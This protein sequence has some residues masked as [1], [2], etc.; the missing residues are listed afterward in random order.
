MMSCASGLVGYMNMRKGNV[1]EIQLTL[2]AYSTTTSRPYVGVTKFYSQILF[3]NAPNY[4]PLCPSI[5]LI[6]SNIKVYAKVSW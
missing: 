4:C 2:V 5:E 3:P 1:C 6:R